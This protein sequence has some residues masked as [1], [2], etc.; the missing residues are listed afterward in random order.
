[1]RR[2]L[3]L[4][5]AAQALAH[6]AV[7]TTVTITTTVTLAVTMTRTGVTHAMMTV[8][9]HVTNNFL[10]D[11]IYKKGGFRLPF[12]FLPKGVFYA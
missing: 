8:T 10:K 3:Y 1:M 4:P 12:S 7:V 6:L 9:G 11:Y 2:L 5:A